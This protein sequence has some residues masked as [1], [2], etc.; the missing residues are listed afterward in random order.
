MTMEPCVSVGKFITAE[1]RYELVG[2]IWYY[3]LAMTGWFWMTRGN[4]LACMGSNLET[5]NL[6]N[7]TG[8]VLVNLR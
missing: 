3:S 6:I 2:I 4:E 1:I 8:D 5:R 7:G